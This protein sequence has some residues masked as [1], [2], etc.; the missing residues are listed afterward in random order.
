MEEAGLQG[1]K[2]IIRLGLF[3]WG[4][5]LVYK[6]QEEEPDF[7]DSEYHLFDQ[8]GVQQRVRKDRLG[9]NPGD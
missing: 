8:T 7:L 9:T 2:R 4:H 1:S 5:G 6:Q 3:I